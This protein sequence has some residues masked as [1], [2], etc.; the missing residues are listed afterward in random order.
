V[1]YLLDLQDSSGRFGPAYHPQEN[2]Y[3][4]YHQA[5]ATLALG[6]AYAMSRDP[7][8]APAARRGVD[9]ILRAQQEGGGWDYGDQPTGRN[10]TSVTGWQLMALK[11][12]HAAG[13]EV[14][15]QPLFHSLRY[16]SRMT[17]PR[18][19]VSYA[20]QGR[21]AWRR[22]PGMVAV[23]MVCLEILG[24]PVEAE[25][26]AQQTDHLLRHAP[27]WE[28]LRAHDPQRYLHTLYYWYHATL[29][30]FQ[31][32]GPSW[33]AWNERLRPALIEQQRRRGAER[34]SWDPPD[35]GFDSVGGRV[36]TTAM[37]TLTLEVY[38]RYLPFQR[39]PGFDALD[40]L[41]RAAKVRGSRLRRRALRLLGHYPGREAEAILVEALDDSDDASRRAAVE[42][43]VARGSL[44]VL[45]A[46]RQDLGRR[47]AGLRLRAIGQ[48]DR[49]GRPA[50]LRLLLDALRDAERTV[51][52]RAAI[53]LRRL[54]GQRFGF[55]A[56]AVA[57]EREAAIERWMAWW[58]AEHAEPP[59]DLR[60]SV[61]VMDPSIPDAVVL[62]VGRE[63]GVREGTR[64][65]VV[66][67]GRD[68]AVL[69]AQRLK[70]GM[71]I[72]RVLQHQ[73]GEIRAGDAVR[74]LRE[75][76]EGQDAD[77]RPSP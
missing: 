55:E 69:E 43:L 35:S 51:R 33:A 27:D 16:L 31:I 50:V 15:W 68:I 32:G 28:S 38:Y 36:Y 57:K 34:G 41:S 77:G 63:H 8:L 40:L 75:S 66:R 49:L 5:I 61:L 76:A 65:Q 53:A 2:R 56:A 58:H 11:S 7:R 17:D 6:E 4:M 22:G 62:D 29:A 20:D 46:L 52:H 48:L 21:H 14:P 24:W 42:A 67:D 12:A 18:G 3:L 25:V 10:D 23:G 47:E 72:A 37:A 73:G 45:P 26:F 60:G 70:Q 30:L 19:Q 1:A 9:V 13:I 71:T 39:S 64:F 54:T 59:A 74:V 44:A